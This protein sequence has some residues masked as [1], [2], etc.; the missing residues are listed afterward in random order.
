MKWKHKYIAGITA[1]SLFFALP[2]VSAEDDEIVVYGGDFEPETETIATDETA[3][4]VEIPKEQMNEPENTTVDTEENQSAPPEDTSV[5]DVTPPEVQEPVEEIKPVV[6]VENLSTT[7]GDNGDSSNSENYT[8]NPSIE[9]P[10]TPETPIETP[11]EEI[12]PEVEV[13]DLSTTNN[14][15]DGEN[16][17]VNPPVE[18]PV[19]TTV[20][21][22]VEE[23]KTEVENNPLISDTPAVEEN[24]ENLNDGVT[25]PTGEIEIPIEEMTTASDGVSDTSEFYDGSD[26]D[27]N[28]YTTHI[29]EPFTGDNTTGSLT[30]ETT[31]KSTKTEKEKKLKTQKARFVKLL[32]DE[33]YEYYLDRSAV[34]WVNMPYSTSEYMADVWIR[35]IEK[36][37]RN[38]DDLYQ[39]LSSGDSEIADAAER[40]IAYTEVD[41]KVLRSKKYF[42]EHYYIRPKTKQ[43]QFLCELEVIGRPQNAISERPY[44]YKNWENLIPGSVESYIYNG[45][46]SEIGTG[47][48]NKRGHMTFVDMLDEYARIALN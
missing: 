10:E 8:D 47:K 14:G 21:I 25:V 23:L 16:Y 30:E 4:I 44:E 42:L 17:H 22:P 24:F 37:D 1:M 19:E 31:K 28:G 35:M 27:G 32:S 43:I 20:E 9:T 12:K 34:R 38:S 2:L 41:K 3:P 7:D 40:G 11:V 26:G 45:V 6:E 36:D 48:A 46:L 13:E 15:D 18:T 5:E 39:Y 33:T 29:Q